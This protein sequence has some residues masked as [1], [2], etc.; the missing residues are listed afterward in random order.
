MTRPAVDPQVRARQRRRAGIVSRAIADLIDLLVVLLIAWLI[1]A[2][3][4]LIRAVLG[5]RLEVLL[6]EPSGRALFMFVLLVAYLAYG[7][8]LNG[9]TL[10]KLVIGLRVVRDDGSDLSFG[11]AL[12]RAFLY[13]VF[14]IGL[15]W[16]VI[17][18]KDASVQDLLLGTAVMYDWGAI[19]EPMHVQCP[20]DAATRR[21]GRGPWGPRRD[22]SGRWGRRRR[23]RV[24]AQPVGDPAPRQ[25]VGRELDTDAVARVH[26]DP[27]AAHL[28][29][30]LREDLMALRDLDPEEGVGKRLGDVPLDLDPLFLLGPSPG[31]RGTRPSG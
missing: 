8:G 30:E 5:G 29:G 25:V 27:T 28:A 7:W 20:V 12:W 24:G 4:A 19:A 14:P 9:R 1:A 26:P 16:A 10:G 23:V 17:S 15:L 11:R 13:A 3:T 18:R 22:H 6:P 31:L 2:A 21:C